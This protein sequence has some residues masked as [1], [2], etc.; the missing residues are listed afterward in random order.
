MPVTDAHSDEPARLANTIE[1][2]FAGQSKDYPERL[3]SNG[4]RAVL[5]EGADAQDDCAVFS[6]SGEQELVV[7][8][9]YV[10]GPKFRLYE[11]GLLTEYDLGYYL[12]AAN[13]S[14][15]AAMGARPIGVL[16]VVRYPL[17]MT[18]AVFEQVMLG[19]RDACADHGA[20]NVGGDIGGA[21]RLILSATAMGVCPPGRSVLRRGARP[22]DLVCLT[23]PTGIAGAATEYF[24]AGRVSEEIEARYR[25]SLLAS[26]A[27]PRA[28]TAEGMALG[29]SG[30]VTSCQDTSDG[31]KATLEGIAVASGTG[32]TV[33]E[34]ELQVPAEVTA[35]CEFVG[36]SVLPVVMGD[37]VDFELVFTMAPERQD[38]VRAEFDSAG[39]GFHAIGVVTKEPGVLL[40]HLSGQRS[41]LPGKAWRH[42]P[43]QAQ[44]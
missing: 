19:I 39:L 29:K 9:D 13:V 32:I 4:S 43:E 36:K 23:A 16:T 17:D 41:P 6:F 12:V 33:F 28:R 15:V 10:R 14:D 21:E 38:A 20:P 44:R 27:R 18:D 7:G 5:A 11:R 24:R 26:W 2:V 42:A 8:S 30:V 31:L 40:E 3:L 37:S 34:Q 35:V 25:G 1:T 22:G